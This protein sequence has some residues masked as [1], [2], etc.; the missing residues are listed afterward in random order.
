MRAQVVEPV[1]GPLQ[2][3]M[4]RVLMPVQAGKFRLQARAALLFWLCMP[5]LQLPAQLKL[6]RKIGVVVSYLKK[7]IPEVNITVNANL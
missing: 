3:V 7:E 4:V 1:W 2:Q 5:A 6:K